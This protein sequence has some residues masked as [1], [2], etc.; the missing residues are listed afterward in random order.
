[1][2]KAATSYIDN[3]D[4]YSIISRSFLKVSD[5]KNLLA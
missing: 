3:M 1:M 5:F 2:R 4:E